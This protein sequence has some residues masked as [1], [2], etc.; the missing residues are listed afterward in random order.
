[1][2][3]LFTLSLIVLTTIFTACSSG[4]S[5]QR[6]DPDKAVDLSGRWN[7][8]DSKLVAEAM[9]KDCLGRPWHS[10]FKLANDQKKPVVIVGLVKNRT[11]E[12]INAETFINDIEKEMIN[13]GLIRVVQDPEFRE[14]LRKERGEQQEF[15][16]KETKKDWKE[17]I[18]ADYMLTGTINATVDQAGREKVIAYQIDLELSNIETNEKIWLG[19][20]KIKKYIKD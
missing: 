18:G 12:H 1:M 17:E 9:I 8:T 6:I 15:A 2:K 10:D 20:H 16:S 5:V 3:N 7:D 19:D 13:S 11:H 4:K 14:N